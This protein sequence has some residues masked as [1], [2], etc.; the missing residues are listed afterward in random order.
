MS[1]TSIHQCRNLKSLIDYCTTPKVG[2]ESDRI[3]E[4]YSDLG[5]SEQFLKYGEEI[6]KTHNRKVQGFSLL[7]SFP[8]NEFDVQNKEHISVVNELGRKLAY[9]LYPNS[10]C[11][12]ITHA[13]SI[14]A[15][16]H[17]HILVL[18][19]DLVSDGCIK[20]NR[21]YKY[22]RRANDRLMGKY[23]LEVCT[24]S[25]EHHSQGE[26]WSNKRNNW[27]EQLKQGVDKALL[28]ACSIQEFHDNL[29]AEGITP[30]LYKAN[31]TLKERFTYTITDCDGKVH[32]KRSDKL[33]EQYSRE[34]IEKT[35]LYNKSKRKSDE[36]QT[37][38]MSMSD[39]IELQKAKE[40]NEKQLQLVE[41][42]STPKIDILDKQLLTSKK[43]STEVPEQEMTMEKDI[44]KEVRSQREK[45]YE[46]KRKELKRIQNQIE[47]L[48][49]EYNED[50][51]DMFEELKGLERDEKKIRAALFLLE[52]GLNKN[53]V[54]DVKLDESLLPRY[55][56]DLSKDNDFSL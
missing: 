10:P 9:N 15:C 48:N 32:K 53:S 35:L 56:S 19:H 52:K 50:D 29:L 23:G 1:V 16:L 37:P 26:Y 33:G 42:K 44:E 20:A 17:N 47:L 38:I 18:N 49:K 4:M 13:D 12:V 11:L 40:R 36:E 25:N 28:N 55:F 8:K 43:E 3:A 30:T 24:P 46:E 34:T 14:G 51:K 6:I 41:V 7:Q 21:H 39:W 27:L 31:R 22:V 54:S 2:Q 45:E 5:D